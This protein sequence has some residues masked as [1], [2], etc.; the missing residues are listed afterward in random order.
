MSSA[1]L[2]GAERTDDFGGSRDPSGRELEV[3]VLVREESRSVELKGAVTSA[4]EVGVSVTGHERRVGDGQEAG[5]VGEGVSAE[6]YQGRRF[7]GSV[8]RLNDH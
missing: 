7:D 8:A 6:A 4:R 1:N 5:T 3:E 2:L